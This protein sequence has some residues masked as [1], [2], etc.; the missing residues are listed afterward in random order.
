MFWLRDTEIS[1][2]AIKPSFYPVYIDKTYREKKIYIIKINVE[3]PQS[4][5]IARS[6]V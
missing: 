1:K 5:K 6:A 3:A 4:S 2:L